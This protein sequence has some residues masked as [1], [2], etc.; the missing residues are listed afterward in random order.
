VPRTGASTPSSATP[1]RSISSRLVPRTFTPTGVRTPVESMSMRA[2][3]G[4]V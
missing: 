4:M 2:L 1:T 3:M